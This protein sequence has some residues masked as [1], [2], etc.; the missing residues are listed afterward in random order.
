MV[1]HWLNFLFSWKSR[2]AG[3]YTCE[4]CT[5]FHLQEYFNLSFFFNVL[6]QK[7]KDITKQ[8]HLAQ[9]GQ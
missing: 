6:S 2:Q 8:R 1:A 9:Q 7:K 5:L 4:K 3:S